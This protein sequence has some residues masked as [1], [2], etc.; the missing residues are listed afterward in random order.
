MMSIKPNLFIVGAAK[1]GTS[2]LA[3]YL[4]QHPQICMSSMKEPF[5]F[6]ENFGI[7]DLNEYLH[8]FNCNK[9]EV[10]IGEASTGYLYEKTAAQ[11]IKIFQP[12]AKIII[13]LRNPINMAY[14]YWRYMQVEGNE[15]KSFEEAI[16]FTESE[17]RKT[18]KFTE[19]CIN[20]PK[21]YL[22]IERAKYANQVKNYIDTFG[23]QNVKVIIFEKFIK[24]IREELVDIFD[25]LGVDRNFDPVIKVKNKG[26]MPRS[27]WIRDNIYNK[28]YPLLRKLLPPK[29]REII[30]YKVRDINRK[31]SKNEIDFELRMRLKNEFASDIRKLEDVLSIE[32][33]E[34]R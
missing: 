25:Y 12:H 10:I 11:K 18:K 2:S 19:N 32:I 26:G 16:S 20:W 31:K 13:M 23:Y 17:Y 27:L 30:R 14:S 15:N 29:W 6:V 3:D 7:S 28:E 22:Y 8:L 5:F 24:D 33:D 1:S 4:S 21:S 34:W 9:G